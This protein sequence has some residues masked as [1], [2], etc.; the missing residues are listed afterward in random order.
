MERIYSSLAE[1]LPLLSPLGPWRIP[2]Q[3]PYLI[4][5]TIAAFPANY[6]ELPFVLPVM[7]PRMVRNY[8]FWLFLIKRKLF[9]VISVYLKNNQL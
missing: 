4:T 2:A 6:L 8:R 3:L 7:M 1:H 5:Q 9:Y